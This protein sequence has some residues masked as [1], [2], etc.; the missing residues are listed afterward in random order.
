MYRAWV[1]QRGRHFTATTMIADGTDVRTVAALLGHA[2]PSLTVRT[3]VHS[4]SELTRK[5]TDRMGDLVADSEDDA[6]TK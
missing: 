1:I 5:A 3:Y 6:M 4:V 2:D